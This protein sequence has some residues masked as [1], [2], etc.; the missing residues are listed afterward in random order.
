VEPLGPLDV[1][2]AADRIAGRVRRTPVVAFEPG[3]FAVPGHLH[4]KLDQLQ[5][6]GS[7]K[8]RGATNLLAGSSV[9]DAGVVAASGG[10]F[11]LA[12]AWAARELGHRA[13]IVVPDTSPA[14]KRDPLAHLGADVEVV[15]GTYADALRYADDLVARTG[16]LRAHAYDHPLVVAGQGTIA[17]E[18]L[19]DLPAVDT[20]VV[21]VGGGGLAA[22]V[23]A[24]V[25]DR[26]RIVAVETEG[27]PTL[28]GALAAG[29]PVDVEVG[30]IAVSALGA[31]RL[32]DHAWAAR[33]H[34]DVALTVTDGEV[35]AAQDALWSTARLQAEPA[36]ATA[37]AA[38]TS[39]AYV[40]AAGEVVA[41]IVCGAN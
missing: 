19:A 28:A 11:G 1:A 2:A 4:L 16:A 6:T 20:I 34:L 33:H 39:G 40:P 7:F 29:H 13:T 24:A 18:I 25:E 22:G 30:G 3:A 5:P 14:S 9:P 27:C 41:V 10:N 38:L 8:V 36:G 23:C 35:V 17:G 31:R 32:G 37:L 21:A 15:P 12:V 26:V